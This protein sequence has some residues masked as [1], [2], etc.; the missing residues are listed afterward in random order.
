MPAPLPSSS[1][2]VTPPPPHVPARLVR[3]L[4]IYMPAPGNVDMFQL[5]HGIKEAGW[6]PIF[7]TRHNGGH[8]IV[9][10]ADLL[11]AV[12]KDYEHFS[13]ARIIV[14]DER[15]ADQPSIPINLDPPDHTVYRELLSHAFSIKNVAAL[16][17]EIRELTVSLIE[18][19]RPHGQCDFVTDFAQRMPI[20][21]F[22]RLVDLPDSDRLRLVAA[23]QAL[24]HPGP[25]AGKDLIRE[26]LA[27]YL[28]PI[29]AVR[30]AKPAGDLIS[31]L[32]QSEVFGRQLNEAE[33]LSMCVL[34]L[35]GGLDSVAATL[36]FFARHLADNVA[37]RQRLIAEPAL[38]PRAVEELLRRYP[39][40]VGAGRIV[41]KE[42]E[43]ADAPMMPGD[44][45][46][47]PTNQANFDETVFAN[48]LHVDLDR[49]PQ[50]MTFGAGPHICPGASLAR[51]E[52]AIFI[53]EWL[54]LIPDFRVD[55][56][57]QVKFKPGINLSY[58]HL[59]LTWL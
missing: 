2:S 27:S 18:A 14:P 39:T 33:H 28:A 30:R 7:W 48:P 16:K 32:G 58:D 47:C 54:R 29:I 26:T 37:H 17:P 10:R 22:M 6:P 46:I 13:S 59:P 25:N 31:R 24:I 53:E 49:R 42:I 15:N 12:L 8:W 21:V 52:L 43:L 56:A 9:S 50:I 20:G 55:P 1:A 3:D 4:D 38:I 57:A 35:I 51:A 45:V 19:V 5:F 44:H 41:A 36:G 34:L 11:P 40:V 23:V